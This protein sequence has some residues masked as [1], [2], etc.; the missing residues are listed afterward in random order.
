M[1][2][3]QWLH[4]NGH[5]DVIKQGRLSLAHKALIEQAV[6]DGAQIDGFA[7]SKAEPK[8][9]AEKAAPRVEKVAIPGQRILDV[10]DERRSESMWTAHTY[11]DGTKVP[12]GMRQVC[13]TCHNSLT[14]CPCRVPV[15]W[16]DHEHTGVVTFTPKR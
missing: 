1:K 7:V 5:L 11:L 15:V 12:V 3:K 6:R 16:I 10:P 14:Y 4:A 8:T 2:P 13:N 9:E